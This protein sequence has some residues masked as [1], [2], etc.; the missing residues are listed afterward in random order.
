MFSH[1]QS[2]LIQTQKI[3]ECFRCFWK[4]FC[5][6]KNWKI[7]K[8]VLPCFG[9][10]VAGHSS[11]MLQPRARGSFL[12]TCSQV[13]GLVTRGTQKFSQLNL[14]LPREW[15]FQSRKTLS[16]FFQ[17][18]RL[19]VLWR[20]SLATCFSREKHVFC[21]SKTVFKTFLVFPSNFC[22]CSLSSHFSLNWNWPKHSS[23]SISASSHLKIFKKKVWVFSV[24]LDFSCFKYYFLDFWAVTVFWD[25]LCS[26][27]FCLD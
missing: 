17:I 23:N 4:V 14:R 6:Y 15:D 10:S 3:F 22:D 13:E 7:S 11:R 18:F 9:D 1:A 5:F 20:V 16:K 8:T 12:A 24:L 27:F 19:E 25:I 2:L 26:K 21:V